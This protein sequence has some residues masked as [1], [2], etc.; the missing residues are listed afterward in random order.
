MSDYEE[1]LDDFPL[2]NINRQAESMVGSHRAESSDQW[3]AGSG[4]TTKIPPLFDGSASPVLSTRSA[5]RR[6]DLTVLEAGKRGPALKNRLVGD[7]E[8]YKGLFD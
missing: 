3:T 2:Q 1:D 6:L 5:D 8:M 7:A 4:I